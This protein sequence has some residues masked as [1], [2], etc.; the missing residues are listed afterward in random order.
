VPRRAKIFAPALAA[1][2]LLSFGAAQ[3]S[4]S[5]A[6]TKAESAAIK[7]GFFKTHSKSTTKITRIRVSTADKAFAAVTYTATLRD[8]VRTRI[9]A[10]RVYKP[11]PEVLKKKSAKWKGPVKPPAKVKKD[12]KI[13]SP[14]SLIKITGDITATLT[15]A[16]T[17]DARTGSVGIYDK[18]SDIYFSIEFHGTGSWTG[19]GFYDADAVRSIATIRRNQG[20]ELAYESGQPKDAF[21]KSG[22]FYVDRGWGFIGADMARPTG[23]DAPLSVSVS[24]AWACG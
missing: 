17:C 5:R 23:A 13:K 12:F 9:M 18:A 6:P 8:P 24:G 11:L 22:E 21:S 7:K 16:A 14:T 15:K 2:L 4:A 3:A 20:T 10:A 19:P 1:L